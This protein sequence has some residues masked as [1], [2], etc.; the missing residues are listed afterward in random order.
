[1]PIGYVK[2]PP[3]ESNR[4]SYF[5]IKGEAFNEAE[6]NKYFEDTAWMRPVSKFSWIFKP[7]AVQ[8]YVE[9]KLFLDYDE[10][11]YLVRVYASGH[12]EAEWQSFIIKPKM[13]GT[14]RMNDEYPIV[15]LLDLPKNWLD[16]RVLKRKDLDFRHW[17]YL[18]PIED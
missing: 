2:P 13:T 3:F 12:H 11:Y 1:L 5:S 10:T 18:K 8:V 6:I 15:A 14:T 17:V 7:S 9:D 16:T 4:K